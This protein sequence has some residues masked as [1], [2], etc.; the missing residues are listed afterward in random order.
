MGEAIDRLDFIISGVLRVVFYRSLHIVSVPFN[1]REVL[2][3][4]EENARGEGRFGGSVE[5]FWAG[6]FILGYRWKNLRMGEG[7]L[8][9]MRFFGTRFGP[10][11]VIY[12]RRLYFGNFTQR[13]LTA[14]LESLTEAT[15]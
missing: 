14:P 11:T 4:A 13:S 2:A 12:R 7:L 8:T 15:S 3:Y 5:R 9:D 10:Q 6:P 1:V